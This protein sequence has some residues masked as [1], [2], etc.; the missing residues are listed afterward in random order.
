MHLLDLECEHFRNLSGCPGSPLVLDPHPRFNIFEGAN[1]QGKTNLLEAI[2]V[3]GTLRSFREPRTRTLVQWDADSAIVRGRIERRGVERTL[4]VELAPRGRRAMVDG[5]AVKRLSDYFG[6]LHMV[7]FGPEDLVL[8][9]GGPSNRRSFLDRAIFNERPVYLEEARAYQTALEH[10]NELLRRG[11]PMV[12]DPAVMA[13]FDEQL[14]TRGARVLRRRLTF[15]ARYRPVFERVFTRITGGSHGVAM[16]YSSPVLAQ[17][18]APA[19]APDTLGS[20]DPT[21]PSEATLGQGLADLLERSRE[22]D[23]RRRYTTRGPHADDLVLTLDAHEARTH[24]SQGQHRAFAL[25]LKI[26]EL[27]I[28]EE[29][30][31]A[32]PVLLLDDVSS[33]LDRTRNAQLMAHLDRSGGQVFITTTDRAW[34]QVTGDTRVFR[35]EEGS[36][37]H[38]G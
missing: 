10:R 18:G 17:I 12:Q 28:A 36:V 24:A 16:R 23:G 37:S 11:G 26:A 7:V 32:A 19:A 15:L 6:H 20:D 27:E 35:V 30:L 21:A 25:A 33:E 14:A 8:T 3:L 9:K 38:D 4:A 22:V 1:G 31:G 5:K 34:I 29:A 13:S 2:Y